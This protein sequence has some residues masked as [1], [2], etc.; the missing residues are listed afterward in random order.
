[1]IQFRKKNISILRYKRLYFHENNFVFFFSLNNLN[2]DVLNSF[3][4]FCE[5]HSLIVLN[6][7]MMHLFSK[8][9]KDLNFLK[10]NHLGFCCIDLKF[11]LNVPYLD[12]FFFNRNFL[13]LFY[14]SFLNLYK[15][16]DLIFFLEKF[17]LRVFYVYFQ[18]SLYFFFFFFKLY[19]WLVHFISKIIKN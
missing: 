18:F 7:D 8:S 3:K 2:N 9:C 15:I 17:Q 12:V 5:L 11:L 6:L 4:H 16:S 10:S 1:M 19:F 14:N 13:F